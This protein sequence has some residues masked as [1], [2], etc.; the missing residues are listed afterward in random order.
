MKKNGVAINDDYLKELGFVDF[1]H[2]DKKK[3]DGQRRM[4]W[5]HLVDG[6]I[7]AIRIVLIVL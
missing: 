3:D 5:L 2:L 1:V 6:E 4:A 7:T